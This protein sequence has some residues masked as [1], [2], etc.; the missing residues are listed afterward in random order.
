M[1]FLA[2]FM[3]N[4]L[5]NF[6]MNFFPIDRKYIDFESTSPP[7]FESFWRNKTE[8]K[9]VSVSTYLQFLCESNVFTGVL[10][11]ILLSLFF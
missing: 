10:K 3:E 5:M 9:Y 4:F 8:T 11:F 7:E 1:N 2:N 6:V